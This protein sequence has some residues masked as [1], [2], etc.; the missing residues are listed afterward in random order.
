MYCE[1]TLVATNA[2]DTVG[3]FGVLDGNTVIDRSP[4]EP[5]HFEWA[6]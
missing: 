6:A 3:A 2:I 4:K 1:M 5:H